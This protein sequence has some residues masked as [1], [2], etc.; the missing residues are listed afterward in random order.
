MKSHEQIENRVP[1]DLI[2]LQD[3]M[4][5]SFVNYEL[6]VKLESRT[7][8]EI[9]ALANKAQ[10]FFKERKAGSL[11]YVGEVIVEELK[12]AHPDQEK[13]EEKKP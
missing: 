6:K 1:S 13:T 2:P 4:I 3:G 10:D 9:N 11:G 7:Q 8:H 12:K 5:I